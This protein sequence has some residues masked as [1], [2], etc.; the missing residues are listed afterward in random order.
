MSFAAPA[1]TALSTVT[2]DH[3]PAARCQP[4]PIPAQELSGAELDRHIADTR[5]LMRLAQARL[6]G[7]HSPRDARE[8]QQWNAAMSD[9]IKARQELI[10]ADELTFSGH[11][12]DEITKLRRRMRDQS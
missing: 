11:W 10:R 8:A 3:Q 1:D 7:S 6:R 12:S 5:F 2:V 9:A 4:Q